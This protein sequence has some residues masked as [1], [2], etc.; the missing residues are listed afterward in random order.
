M[1][2]PKTNQL[3]MTSTERDKLRDQI[4][5]HWTNDSADMEPRSKAMQRWT[6]LTHGFSDDSNVP[7][8]KRSNF[9]IPLILWMIINKVAKE[10]TPLLGEDSEI[11]VVPVGPSDA[12]RKDKVKRW[13]TFRVKQLKLFAKYY[14]HLFKKAENGTSILYVPW[15]TRTRLVKT[16]KAGTRPVEDEFEDAIDEESQLPALVPKT[17][18]FTED[19][20]EEVTTFDGIDPVP[21]NIEDWA[22]PAVATS[23]E[24]A[25]HFTRR[26]RLTL[27]EIHDLRDTNKISPDL[28]TDSDMDRLAELSE[29]SRS[30][31]SAQPDAGAKVRAEKRQLTGVPVDGSGGPSKIV[32]YNYFGKLRKKKGSKAVEIV[33]FYSPSLKK[34]LGVAELVEMFP[35]GKVPF[36]KS[37][38]ILNPDS[39]WG[40]GIPEV[41]ESI[42]RE[43]NAMHNIVTD[44]GMM[45]VAP[46]GA[47][48]PIAGFDA[49]KFEY[50]PGIMLPLADPER[51]LV[52]KSPGTPNLQIY[53]VLMPALLQM[54][55]N[56]IG[57]T[58]PEIGRQFTG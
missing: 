45:A 21:E 55:E 5:K 30:E 26:L 6:K 48:K 56:L 50:G 33:A 57:L 47:Y 41:L 31:T 35:D 34:V 9:H 49:T 37:P 15:V 19:N 10:I 7:D 22:I 24:D 11:V 36:I 46:V 4:E 25:D 52:F 3:E 13:M 17:E 40:K 42:S 28:L 23:F 12:A 14:S 39:F 54:A 20:I 18:T 58:Q 8:H 44:A 38:L 1:P 16:V 43:M 29:E 51:D 53:A 27:D 2:Q 32:I